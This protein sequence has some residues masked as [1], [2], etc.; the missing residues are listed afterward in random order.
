DAVRNV[1]YRIH[2][3]NSLKIRR[4]R[5][6]GNSK[7]GIGKFVAGAAAAA[8]VAL[9]AAP[10]LDSAKAAPPPEGEKITKP[11]GASKDRRKHPPQAPAAVAA[12]G[13]DDGLVPPIS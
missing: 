13:S 3:K 1:V 4:A 2:E 5:Y 11:E 9:W 10:T 6:G 8:S 12:N 7:G